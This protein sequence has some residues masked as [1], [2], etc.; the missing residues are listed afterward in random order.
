MILK[1]RTQ[2]PEPRT[3]LVILI[4]F[5][6]CQ[7]SFV[8]PSVFAKEIT[9][10]YSGETHA[11]LYTCSCPI[12]NDGGI[13]RRATLLKQ[14]RKENPD[15]LVL[16][17]GG[18]FAGG[19]LDE[20]TQNTQLDTQRTLVNLKA[21]ELMKYDAVAV[22]DDEFD[23]GREFFQENIVKTKLNFLSCNLK[24]EKVLPFIIKDVSGIKVGITGVTSPAA[25]QKAGGLQITDHMA[26]VAAA[27]SAA[28][29]AGANII[30]L[31]SHLGENEDLNLI[32]S[33]PGI[34]IIITGH[35][36]GKE[37]PYSK[38]GNTVLLRPT[39]QGRKLGKATFEV[40]DN[41][42]TT[43]KV[44]NIRLSDK[45]ADDPE[46]LTILPRC[47]SDRNCKKEGL[48]GAC[49]NPGNINS[50]CAFTEAN[51]VS[52]SVITPKNCA[53]CNSENVVNFLKKQLPGLSVSYIYYPDKKS[54]SL[55]KDFSI[56][57]LPA[58]LF[59]REVEKDRA[60]DSLKANLDLKGDYY[61]LKPRV[62]GFS[63]FLNRK[64]VSGKADLFI[65]LYENNIPDLLEVNKEFSPTMHFLA[66]EQE[67]KLDAP[68]GALEIED[69]L[70]AVCVQ[71]Y[72]PK[73]FWDYI[74]CRA[75]NVNTSWWE[76]CAAGMDT[77]KIK[78]CAKSQEGNSLLRENIGLN[79]ELEI[80]F[81][82][83]YLLDNQ[84]IFATK[85]V[86]TKEQLKK[87]FKR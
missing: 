57:A 21:M 46:M 14:L 11:M 4:L 73:L 77:N 75:K 50:T 37:E 35:N 58:Y 47:F 83:T 52:L 42:V 22:G 24:A 13:A 38:I 31:L 5:V 48:I 15:V 59:G 19:L 28:K 81:G 40:K 34:D 76:D 60:F 16:D 78:A 1:L 61:M 54:E 2:N 10:L 26:S 12:E 33:V 55:I 20:Y 23:F 36:K 70:R 18:F 6:I 43:L 56:T 80:M 82:P 9:I 45:L 72:Y 17:S 74:S 8:V 39:W 30:V 49:Q 7:L 84:E 71:K 44:E 41:S 68:K 3:P 85:A 79:K 66:V 53:T 69:D 86:P 65:S 51:K 25:A 64:K 32:N 27:V 67:G 29:Q 63:F 62:S 87:I